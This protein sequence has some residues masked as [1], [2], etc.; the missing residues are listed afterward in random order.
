MK[1]LPKSLRESYRYLVFSL[2]TPPGEEV[3]ESDLQRTI[4]FEAQNLY[5]DMVSSEAGLRLIEYRTQGC[6]EPNEHPD[7]D[8]EP[9]RGS[10]DGPGFGILKC[11][12]EKVDQ[13]R[14]ALAC[15]TE[16]GDVEV[17]PVVRGVSGTVESGREKHVASGNSGSVVVDGC[18]GYRWGERLDLPVGDDERRFSSSGSEGKPNFIGLTVY[19]LSKE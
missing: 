5:G 16:V 3:G 18:E 7:G 4:W 2:E 13:A 14:A 11:S 19:D 1:G 6:L 15:V 8:G 10:V 17:A 9:G 12:R